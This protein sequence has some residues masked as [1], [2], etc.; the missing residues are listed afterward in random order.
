MDGNTQL[1]LVTNLDRDCFAIAVQV[2]A[3]SHYVQGIEQLS[4]EAGLNLLR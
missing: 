4:H 1:Q 2:R 3:L